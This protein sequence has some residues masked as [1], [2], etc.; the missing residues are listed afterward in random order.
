MFSIVNNNIYGLEKSL[1]FKNKKKPQ[2]T[3]W[4]WGKKNTIFSIQALTSEFHFSSDISFSH[5]SHDL[6]DRLALTP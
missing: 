6:F 4:D 2:S 5:H 3:K 1:N